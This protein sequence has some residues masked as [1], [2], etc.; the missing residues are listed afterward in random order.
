MNLIISVKNMS[1]LSNINKKISNYYLI[2]SKHN[3]IR[4]IILENK[5]IKLINSWKRK[6][7]FLTKNKKLLVRSREK[8]LKKLI[9]LKDF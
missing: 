6:I 5:S 3:K 4:F 9:D 7:K 1:K 2:I 8:K